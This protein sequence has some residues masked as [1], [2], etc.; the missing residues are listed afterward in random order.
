MSKAHA[1]SYLSATWAIVA[2]A[3]VAASVQPYYTPSGPPHI[4]KV[5][6]FAG[7]ALISIFPRLIF[8]RQRHWLGSI[9]CIAVI[10]FA[11]EGLQSFMPTRS[12]QWGDVLANLAGIAFGLLLSLLVYRIMHR[13]SCD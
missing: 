3:L 12:A 8:C 1:H 11:T 9:A 13:S 4:D 2:I 7:Y 6:H 10:A 5:L